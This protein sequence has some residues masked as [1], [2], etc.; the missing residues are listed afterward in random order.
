MLTSIV[1]VYPGALKGTGW[2]NITMGYYG[3]DICTYPCYSTAKVG[4]S[5]TYQWEENYE[6]KQYEENSIY[7]EFKRLAIAKI[8]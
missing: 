2:Q 5:Q 7:F 3:R 4:F 1:C 6:C 8:M